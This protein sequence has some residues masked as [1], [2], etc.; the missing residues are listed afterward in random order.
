MGLHAGFDPTG[1]NCLTADLEAWS[2][3]G[4]IPKAVDPPMIVPEINLL[5]LDAGVHTSDLDSGRF[6]WLRFTDPLK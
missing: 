3:L 2:L 5:R 4:S 1:F 6:P